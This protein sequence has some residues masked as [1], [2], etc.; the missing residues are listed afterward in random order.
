MYGRVPVVNRPYR[1]GSSVS[2]LLARVIVCALVSRST[3][4]VSGTRGAGVTTRLATRS[5]IAPIAVTTAPS[6][7][8][9]R[10]IAVRRTPAFRG[11]APG[12]AARLEAFIEPSL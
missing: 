4:R 6:E 9:S 10:V 5:V 8:A 7:I 3:I 11:E 12:L 1:P 2:G